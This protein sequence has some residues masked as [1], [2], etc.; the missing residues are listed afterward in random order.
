VS[1]VTRIFALMAL[2][3]LMV[4]SGVLFSGLQLRQN[5]LEELRHDTK[6]LARI[7]E[8][9]MVRILEG[10]HQLLATLA[11]LPMDQGWDARACAVVQATA[12]SDFEYDHIVTVDRDGA[13]ECA[14]SGSDVVRPG[15]LMPDR[16]LFDRIVATAGFSIGAYGIGQVS[17]NEVLRVGYPVVDDTGAV[18]G[19]V[20]AGINLTWLNTAIDQWNLGAKTAISVTDRNGIQIA[21]QP[22]SRGVGHPIAANL[23]PFLSAKESGAV[24]VTDPSGAVNLF[25][26]IPVGG[27][28]SDGIAVFVG[29]DKRQITSDINQSIWLNV[30]A[31]LAGLL[32]SV[33]LALFYLRRFLARPFQ[34]LLTVAGRWQKG[35]WSVRAASASGSP[36]FDRLAAAFDGMA[37]EV[38][39]R[40]LKIS[41]L[42]R[43][44]VLTGLANRTVFAERLEHCASTA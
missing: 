1:I 17:G 34:N 5:R 37:A 28:P 8:L 32:L 35:D 11:K 38:S 13:R 22:N 36:E 4:A 30:A 7:A 41:W 27:G 25:G 31:V 44:D 6:Q 2:T 29:R 24:E 12:N 23:K 19:A 9:D 33:I 14:S 43:H 16:E 10:A 20:Y 26:Y 42:A 3:L 15:T 40:E 21:R 39:S 18:V